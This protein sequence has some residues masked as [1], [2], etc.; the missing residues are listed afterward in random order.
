MTDCA[1]CKKS[2]PRLSIEA[3]PSIK[4][5][6]QSHL[7]PTLTQYGVGNY[8]CY[9]CY[10]ELF[11]EYEKERKKPEIEC[12]N[13]E[14]KFIMAAKTPKNRRITFAMGSY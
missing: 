14:K 9:N 6:I 5:E 10:N 11:K 13:C 2:I 4:I 12:P 3:T 8:L 1:K 7:P